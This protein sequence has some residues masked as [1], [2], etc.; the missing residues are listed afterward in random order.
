MVSICIYMASMFI[1]IKCMCLYVNVFVSLEACQCLINM[2]M[3]VR[4]QQLF[5]ESRKSIEPD[6]FYVMFGSFALPKYHLCLS[7]SR[8][9]MTPRRETTRL[10]SPVEREHGDKNAECRHPTAAERAW[11]T[12]QQCG[13]VRLLSTRHA[14]TQQRNIFH[15]SWREI[16]VH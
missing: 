3:K 2:E 10:S 4:H 13:T 11:L 9:T 15:R 7:G 5:V 1:D 12:A 8:T 14:L 16:T 6:D